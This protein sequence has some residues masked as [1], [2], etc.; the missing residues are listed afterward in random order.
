MIV[1]LISNA[2]NASITDSRF[3]VINK[4]EI[5]ELELTVTLLSPLEKLSFSDEEDLLNQLDPKVHGLIISDQ[6]KRSIFLPE[7]WND[8]PN[9]SL[10]LNQ[11]KVKGG[12]LPNHWSNT[13]QAWRFTVCFLKGPITTGL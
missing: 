13:L 5:P 6:D 7:V 1:D 12:L 10:F 2:Y 8:Y 4:E 9:K 11:L 3:S